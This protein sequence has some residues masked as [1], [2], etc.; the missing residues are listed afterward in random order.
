M[1]EEQFGTDQILEAIDF[2]TQVLH[3]EQLETYG[4]EYVHTALKLESSQ[5]WMKCDDAMHWKASR[6]INPIYE[7]FEVTPQIARLAT[8]VGVV[9]TSGLEEYLPSDIMTDY[10]PN[11]MLPL[12]VADELIG[13]IIS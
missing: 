9:L 2:F 8:K 4:Y 10:H 3:P 7:P 12:I 5:L 1:I 11:F 6:G 13:L